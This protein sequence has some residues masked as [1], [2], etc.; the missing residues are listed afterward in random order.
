MKICANCKH[1]RKV[2]DDVWYNYQCRANP[3]PIAVDPVTG[4]TMYFDKNDVGRIYFTDEELP[5]CRD[6]NLTGDC[7]QYEGKS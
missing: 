2:G 4:K 3:R 5:A 1:L 7:R 6:I